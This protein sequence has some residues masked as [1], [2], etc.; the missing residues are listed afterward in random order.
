MYFLKTDLLFI[1]VFVCFVLKDEEEKPSD[2]THCIKE[3]ETED[4][5]DCSIGPQPKVDPYG[6]WVTVEKV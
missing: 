1:C 3:E 6:H 5:N 4:E 2:K